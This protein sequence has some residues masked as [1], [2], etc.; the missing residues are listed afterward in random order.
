M[1]TMKY[2]SNPNEDTAYCDGHKVQLIA[3]P[4]GT[5]QLPI[6][7]TSDSGYVVDGNGKKHRVLM[8]TFLSG[9]PDFK[10]SA[11]EDTAYMTVSGQKVKVRLASKETGTLTLSDKPNV[12]KGYV[13]GGDSEK[14][15]AIL[16]NTPT[17]ILQL[18][19]NETDD[20]AYIVDNNGKKTK[21]RMFVL[22]NGGSQEVII[23]GTSPLSLPDAIANSLSYVKAFGGT[24]QRNLPAGY[25]ALEY[26]ESTGTQYIDTGVTTSNDIKGEIRGKFLSVDTK[27]SMLLAARAGADGYN[28]LIAWN[29]NN[30]G[31][32]FTQFASSLGFSRVVMP[33]D[34]NIHILQGVVTPTS[35]STYA[36]SS[37]DTISAENVGYNLNLYINARNIDGTS[38]SNI[39]TYR[40]YYVKIWKSGSLVRNFIPAKNSSGVVGM[41]D[42]VSG[43]FF[44][45]AGTGDFV[46]GSA[47]VPTPDMP[48][49]I[50]SNNGVLK[51]RHQSG[52]PLGYTLLDYIESTGTQYIDT[53]II[54]KSSIKAEFMVDRPTPPANGAPVWQPLSSKNDSTNGQFNIF[55]STNSG[56]Q[57]YLAL[58]YG[59]ATASDLITESWVSSAFN[60][61]KF[62]LDGGALIV[63]NNSHVLTSSQAGQTFNSGHTLRLFM[64]EGASS[65]ASCTMYYMKLWDGNTLVRN[66]VPCKNAS[67]VVGMYD[68]VSG[69]FFTNAGTGDFTAGTAVSDPVEIYTDGTVETI[70]VHGKNLFDKAD[71][72]TG[73][74][75]N[76][77]GAVV[78]QTN[79][80]YSGHITVRPSTVYTVSQTNGVGIYLRIL[81]Y[82]STNT[83]VKL[84]KGTTDG[85]QTFTF[86]TDANTAYVIVSG[87]FNGGALDTVQIELGST[88]TIYEP[89]F[90]GGT[91]TAEMLLKVGDYQDVQEILAGD[92]TR[93]VGV[94]ALDGS[95]DWSKL[96]SS[97]I[98]Y[99]PFNDVNKTSG[100]TSY[101]SHYKGL[102]NTAS[103]TVE[104]NTIRIG[105]YDS[106]SPAYDRIYVHDGTI[107]D[108]TQFKAF[109]AQQY[110]NGTPV[111]IVYPLATPTTESVAGQTMQVQAGDNL[112][113][114]T[115][116][117]LDNLELEAKYQAAV[118]LTIQEV[119]DAN[120]D[121]NVEV[122]IN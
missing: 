4:S 51:A 97:S 80:Y 112:V 102:V 38:V 36:D 28:T 62:V 105:Y 32:Y 92:V 9:T 16:V 15:R 83:M 81:E 120:L 42:L 49:D 39:S 74:I 19:N 13:V 10:L 104:P 67:N 110:A 103:I 122:T 54:A 71:I 77:T 41:Y 96:T 107:N 25:T 89:Y 79:G 46:A 20:S 1:P 64:R 99:C 63:D 108:L 68:L 69:Q 58:T 21:V 18:P 14:H 37:V 8:A 26:I 48:M 95:E 75:L 40:Y 76:D 59:K 6:H 90:N 31:G 84:N 72:T 85:T 17:G 65:S 119:Q 106:T 109:L 55:E 73:K 101:C 50:V 114:I 7:P 88:A 35:T 60:Q 57:K 94:K 87:S 86:T 5:L 29:N 93:K 45:N 27:T 23:R 113:E 43:T 47:V 52:L 70:N 98:Y 12:N 11:T 61:S 91:A 44:T 30:G 34:T 66:F 82:D 2:K 53:G 117:S 121:P 78:N 22:L 56:G 3:V 111:I 33:K 100:A 118:S 24:E 116:A 115:Q